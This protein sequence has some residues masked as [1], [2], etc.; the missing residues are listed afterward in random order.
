MESNIGPRQKATQLLDFPQKIHI[1]EKT[2]RQ[3]VLEKNQYPCAEEML[4]IFSPPG[5]QTKTTW[6]QSHSTQKSSPA[7]KPKLGGIRAK[8]LLAGMQKPA[9]M[10]ATTWSSYTTADIK[11]SES[12]D[13]RV[14]LHSCADC[15][16]SG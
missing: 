16:A 10:F 8:T 4:N 15:G 1:G 14:S 5:L 3:T 9:N 6:I 12:A 13:R 11:E 7:E 2:V